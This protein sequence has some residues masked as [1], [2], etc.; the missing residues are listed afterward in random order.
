MFDPPQF[1]SLAQK[2][3]SGDEVSVRTSVSRAYYSAFLVAREEL[4]LSRERAPDVHKR[5]IEELRVKSHPVANRLHLLRRMRN[6]ADY[7]LDTCVKSRD[8]QE[9]LTLAMRILRWFK[10]KK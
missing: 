4:G 9:A 6:T 3:A 2:L 1:F 10:T 7:E 8:A 5:V